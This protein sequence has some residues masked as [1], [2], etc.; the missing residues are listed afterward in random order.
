MLITEVLYYGWLILYNVLVPEVFC[1]DLARI[2]TV[3]DGGKWV[4]NPVQVRNFATCVIYSLGINNE[5]SFEAEFAKFTDNKCSIRSFDKNNQKPETI[6][7]IKNSNGTFMK[8]L[9]A[10][11]VNQTAGSYTIKSLMEKFDDER[12]D[13]F[14]IDIEGF[15]YLIIDQFLDIPICQIL[16]EVHGKTAK[17]TL[18]ILRKISQSG[19]YL[20]SYEINGAHHNLSEY[21]FIHERCLKDY[22]VNVVFGKY[23]S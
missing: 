3:S 12:I 20:F 23:L 14:K 8:A 18:E 15:E 1:R 6:K 7:R 21:S 2:G 17:K 16:I 11:E 13:I 19:Y 22:G 5:P 4:C 10:P 9:I